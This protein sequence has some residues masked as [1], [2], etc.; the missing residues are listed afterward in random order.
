MRRVRAGN[1]GQTA[2]EDID[3][4]E[5]IA[6]P[7]Q[8][9]DSSVAVAEAPTV[10]SDH[11]TVRNVGPT[12]VHEDATTETGTRRA[13][14]KSARGPVLTRIAIAGM[15]LVAGLGVVTA[16]P[17]FADPPAQPQG[18]TGYHIL[19]SQN[20]C[21]LV[22]PTSQA[23]PDP[24]EPV[25]TICVR[26]GGLLTRLSRA[27]P[28]FVSDTYK[29]APGSAKELPVG[30]VRIHPNDPLSDWLIPDCNIPNRVD[31]PPSAS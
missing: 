31:C 14:S 30:S 7:R 1:E 4:G 18:E 17:A 16:P 10:L 22:W 15:G 29:L 13:T 19:S 25:G 9:L 26:H 8:I 28:A 12:R 24:A 11:S 23:M 5:Q 21:N 6:Q 2:I 27:F 20:L 3:G